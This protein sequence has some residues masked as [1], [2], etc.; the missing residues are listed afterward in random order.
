MGV[1]GKIKISLIKEEIISNSTQI[2][3]KEE[4]TLPNP[5]SEVITNL[6]SKPDRDSIQKQNMDQSYF[7][8]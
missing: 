5:L 4:E 6:T 8:K 3:G 2:Q 7:R 1:D